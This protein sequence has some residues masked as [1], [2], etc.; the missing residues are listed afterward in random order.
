MALDVSIQY[1]DWHAYHDFMSK[2]LRVV[3][4]VIIEGG[5]FAAE[6]KPHEGPSGIN[7]ESLVL[8]LVVFPTGES[9]SRQELKY[10][11]PWEDGGIQ[12]KQVEFRSEDV[13]PPPPVSVEDV[14]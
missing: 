9:P 7:S 10:E 12:Y 2:R 11:Q 5:G 14:H 1:E 6:L 8:D 13:E 4:T 3:G